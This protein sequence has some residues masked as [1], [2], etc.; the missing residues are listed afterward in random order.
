MTRTRRRCFLFAAVLGITVSSSRR[1]AFALSRNSIHT[2]IHQP[3]SITGD[4]RLFEMSPAEMTT[5]NAG[6]GRTNNKNA[7][8]EKVSSSTMQSRKQA[9]HSLSLLA[10][11]VLATTVSPLPSRAFDRDFPDE[12]T[13]DDQDDDKAMGVLVGKR[14]NAQQRKREAIE[15]KKKLDQNL[16]SF[17]PKQD[18]L[19][20]LTWGLAL[21]FASGSRSNP[22]AR[23]LANLLYDP[24]KEKWL[25][26]R[27]AGLF[28]P[29]PLEF[30][31]LLGVLFV[32]LGTITQ[33]T[34][35][36]LSGGDSGVIGQLAGVAL[37]NGGFFELAR[38]ARYD[39]K[40]PC[41]RFCAT[42]ALEF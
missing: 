2:N 31:V 28:S 26:D 9:L 19:P 10:G 35:L 23:P 18:A 24:Q 38:I 16:A 37:I 34:L 5:R 36:Q 40:I 30:L 7:A 32:V 20:S 8:L 13:D 3:P 33:Y 42:N 6:H 22:L 12:L 21:F 17:S 14:S 27:N 1:I 25:Q 15:N 11:G 41:F 29:L 39:A 4:G